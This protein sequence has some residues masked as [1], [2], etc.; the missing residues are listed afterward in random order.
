M[1]TKLIRTAKNERTY[2]SDARHAIL[3]K[4]SVGE[5]PM[6]QFR[7]KVVHPRKTQPEPIVS[8]GGI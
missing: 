8:Y 3:H 1:T 7:A 4:Q 6:R 2:E 5:Q